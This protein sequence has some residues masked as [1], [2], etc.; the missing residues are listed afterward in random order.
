MKSEGWRSHEKNNAH[1]ISLLCGLML[2]SNALEP[3]YG[4]VGLIATCDLISLS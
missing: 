4:A 3:I 1:G 2:V